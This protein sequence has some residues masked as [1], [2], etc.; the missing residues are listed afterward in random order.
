[1]EL[2]AIVDGQRIDFVPA[3]N[4]LLSML[5]R[6]EADELMSRTF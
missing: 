2:G 5:T 1:M 4:R 6:G 3:L